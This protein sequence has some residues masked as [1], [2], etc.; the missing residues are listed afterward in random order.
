MA[1]RMKQTREG[2]YTA[3]ER[4]EDAKRTNKKK[5]T[6]GEK[7]CR[8][9]TPEMQRKLRESRN[10][11]WNSW[12]KYQAVRLITAEEAQAYCDQGYK[13]IPARWVSLDKN[14]KLCATSHEVQEKL[15]SRLAIDEQRLGRRIIPS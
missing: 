2:P 6:T 5:A 8:N 1:R 14:G 11:E 4:E 15:K 12:K 3:P 9:E 13:A 7:T 10:K